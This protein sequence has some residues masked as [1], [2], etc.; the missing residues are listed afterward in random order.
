LTEGELM[1]LDPKQAQAQRLPRYGNGN[2]EMVTNRFWEAMIRN[3]RTAHWATQHFK[4]NITRD[5]AAQRP[6]AAL[7]GWRDR[8]DGP[9]W[10]FTR[11]GRTVTQLQHGRLVY[12]GGEHEDF[13]DPDFCIYNDV[14]VEDANGEID[15]FLYPAH[16]FPP[17]DFH[18]STLVGDDIYVIGSVGYK[19]HREFGSTP[20]FKIDTQTFNVQKVHT[21]GAEPGWISRHAAHFD[22]RNQCIQI[23]D[24]SVQHDETTTVVNTEQFTLD[25][26]TGE[27]TMG[28]WTL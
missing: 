24:G 16:V 10:C 7:L 6:L 26:K 4:F 11:F 21:T 23:W 5:W 9:T 1:E 28:Q 13:Y 14:V 20:V 15:I 22:R 12:I 2:P 3:R 18:S 17:T 8:H 27:W 25:L 19:D